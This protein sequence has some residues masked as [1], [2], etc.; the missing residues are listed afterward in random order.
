MTPAPKIISR[1]RRSFSFRLIVFHIPEF[2]RTVFPPST[3]MYLP[4]SVDSA[5]RRISTKCRCTLC[6]NPRTCSIKSFNPSMRKT[7]KFSL[8][9]LRHSFYFFIQ[10]LLKPRLFLKVNGIPE[11]F[12]SNVKKP[13]SE[14][15]FLCL[16]NRGY[17]IILRFKTC[18]KERRFDTT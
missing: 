16:P 7:V 18:V 10:V 3:P 4:R 17:K 1:T 11:K 9:F 12:L 14:D 15:R 2:F 6:L 5:L 8:L 13:G